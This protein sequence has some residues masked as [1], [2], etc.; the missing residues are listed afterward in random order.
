MEKHIEITIQHAQMGKFMSQKAFDD[1][2]FRIKALELALRM[3]PSLLDG[4][5]EDDGP[6]IM[7]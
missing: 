3:N 4:F 7:Y 2:E 6:F 5:D 1:W